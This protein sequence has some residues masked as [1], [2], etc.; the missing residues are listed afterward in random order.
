M[1][2]S[3]PSKEFARDVRERLHRLRKLALQTKKRRHFARRKRLARGIVRAARRIVSETACCNGQLCK[4]GASWPV[5]ATY[6]V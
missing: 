5:R 2:S 4:P 1:A 6:S 3:Q